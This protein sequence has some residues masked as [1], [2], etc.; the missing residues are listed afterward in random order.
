MSLLVDLLPLNFLDVNIHTSCYFVLYRHNL[1]GIRTVPVAHE[2]WAFTC[3]AGSLGSNSSRVNFSKVKFEFKYMGILIVHWTSSISMFSI[4]LFPVS[5]PIRW[6]SIEVFDRNVTTLRIEVRS[7]RYS[8]LSH[9]CTSV[10]PKGY[11][12][13]GPTAIYFEKLV[14]FTASFN[15]VLYCRFIIISQFEMILQYFCFYCSWH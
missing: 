5:P 6:L 14:D 8:F 11:C 10:G 9:F 15:T 7:Y 3:R 1:H 12:T 4:G 2:D 13:I